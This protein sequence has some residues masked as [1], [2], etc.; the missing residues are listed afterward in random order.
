VKVLIGALGQVSLPWYASDVLILDVKLRDVN[1]LEVTRGLPT[2]GLDNA[3][4]AR[5]LVLTKRT[6]QKHISVIYAKLAVT[7]RTE[8][9]LDAVLRA[10]NL[11]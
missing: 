6:V 8:A 3:T 1:G 2:Q 10:R 9:L 7:S 5:R 11:P 4:I